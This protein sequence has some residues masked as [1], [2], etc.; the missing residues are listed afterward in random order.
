MF[1]SCDW[2]Y[3]FHR[4]SIARDETE[5]KIFPVFC[6]HLYIGDAIAAFYLIRVSTV[7]RVSSEVTV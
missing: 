5:L 4:G 1:V 7:P 2:H 6:F 3:A